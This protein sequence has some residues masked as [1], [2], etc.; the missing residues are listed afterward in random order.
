MDVTTIDTR[1]D[2][3]YINR[4]SLIIPS[5]SSS[6]KKEEDVSFLRFRN[7]TNE[8]STT[9]SSTQEAAIKITQNDSQAMNSNST[10]ASETGLTIADAR[11]TGLRLVLM[12]D[13]ITRYQYLSLAYFLR[14][15]KWFDP[16]QKPHLVD[17]NSYIRKARA[18]KGWAYFFRETNRLL[19]PMEKCD[20]FRERWP[21]IKYV[22]RYVMENRYFH[23]PE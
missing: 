23:D 7:H 16:K 4:L 2:T 21:N 13:S 18:D 8:A 5:G 17:Q 15:G 19:S 11:P 14:H 10:I 20:C 6:G 12:G 9:A 22:D 1:N 3:E